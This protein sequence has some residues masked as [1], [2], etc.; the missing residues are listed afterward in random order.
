MSLFSEFE[1]ETKEMPANNLRMER[2][3]AKREFRKIEQTKNAIEHL[4]P[5]PDSEVSV[6]IVS[7]ARFDFYDFIPTILHLEKSKCVKLIMAT[8]IINK[9]N[10]DN[11]FKLFD[12]GEIKEVQIL[13]GIYFKRREAANY[14]MMAEGM[15]K[16][17]QKFRA[18]LSHAK[19]FSMQLENGKCFTIES[20]ANMTENGN[21]ETHVLTQSKPLHEFH[22]SW[23]QTILTK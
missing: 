11:L 18:A 8:W 12:D 20:S 14:T 2:R 17:G 6:H 1:I 16:R 15:Q 22:C 21:V 3:A 7:N 19:F 13:T 10:I 9:S 5:L 23:M 4:T